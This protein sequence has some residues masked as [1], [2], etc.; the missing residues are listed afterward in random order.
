MAII[1]AKHL[2][3]HSAAREQASIQA[4][5]EWRQKRAPKRGARKIEIPYKTYTP[6]AVA[7]FFSANFQPT[8][9]E[10]LRYYQDVEQAHSLQK[11]R[12]LTELAAYKDLRKAKKA[13]EE[14][15]KP[16]IAKKLAEDFEHQAQK[17][18]A[19]IPRVG[20]ILRG[21][22]L[23]TLSTLNTALTQDFP[24]YDDIPDDLVLDF[25]EKF[26]AAVTDYCED[27]S[28]SMD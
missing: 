17:V 28:I 9:I 23:L 1:T 3:T 27:N 21:M 5:Y 15:A 14:R 12:F 19:S 25:L 13:L 22:G 8:E 11:Q 10:I 18:I 7:A 2:H 26:E 4:L 20:G 16:L 24:T 6:E